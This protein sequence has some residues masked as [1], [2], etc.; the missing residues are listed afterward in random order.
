MKIFTL[1]AALVALSVLSGL[2]LDGNIV[3]ETVTH[4]TT[5]PRIESEVASPSGTSAVPEA[6]AAAA[7]TDQATQMSLSFSFALELPSPMCVIPDG[8]P[9]YS[10]GHVT[11]IVDVGI[12]RLYSPLVLRIQDHDTHEE[13]NRYFEPGALDI[14][15]SK[16][17][18]STYLVP[19]C[20]TQV[21]R[22]HDSSTLSHWSFCWLLHFSPCLMY[23]VLHLYRKY[24]GKISPLARTGTNNAQEYA[25]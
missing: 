5:T 2:P 25:C 6:N 18:P 3:V 4:L 7:A 21:W 12:V 16:I 22:D 11:S 15:E 9:E 8:R 10:H 20:W 17:H 23:I 1:L 14:P 13:E 24:V 19:Y